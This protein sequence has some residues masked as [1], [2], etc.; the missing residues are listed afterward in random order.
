MAVLCVIFVPK[1]LIHHTMKGKSYEEQLDFL[2][3]HT[4]GGKNA[5]RTQSDVGQRDLNASS[6]LESTYSR[7]YRSRSHP[8]S[9]SSIPED[10]VVLG[11]DD[12]SSTTATN[13]AP[14]DH[15]SAY[16]TKTEATASVTQ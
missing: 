6:S 4:G 11:I 15:R 5:P 16:P 7:A 1:I 13:G 8:P 3:R 12:G 14:I 2:R 9:I 10:R